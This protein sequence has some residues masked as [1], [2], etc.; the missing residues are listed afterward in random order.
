M[1]SRRASAACTS[2]RALKMR[3]FNRRERDLER[4]CDLV[5]GHPRDVAKQERHLQVG[6]SA[7]A[8]RAQTASIV[9]SRSIGASTT[10]EPRRVPRRT[11]PVLRPTLAAP[12]KTRRA[13]DSSSPWKSPGRELAAEGE[14]RQRLEDPDEDLLREVLGEGAVTRQPV[15]VVVDRASRTRAGSGRRRARHPR[16][17]RR[18]TSGSGC[19]SDTCPQNIPELVRK[20][21]NDGSGESK[22]LPVIAAGCS[23]LE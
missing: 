13:R 6:V 4:V 11:S 19:S 18:R 15:D 12:R 20:L 3:H 9:S 17:A 21:T 16:C 8:P 10:L 1:P 7:R 14:T 22:S 2:S 5:V 23:S